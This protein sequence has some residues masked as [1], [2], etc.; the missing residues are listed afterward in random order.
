[1]SNKN[2]NERGFFSGIG[3]ACRSFG[4]LMGAAE[5]LT[6][7]VEEA[8]S[9]MKVTLIQSVK[10]INTGLAIANKNL[11]ASMEDLDDVKAS[12]PDI[13]TGN[14]IAKWDKENSMY[15]NEDGT[16]YKA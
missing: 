12:Y 3:S 16:E 5:E 14:G 7:G 9:E 15:I 10:T 13:D 6:S 1:M 8:A 11:M 4:N 2:K